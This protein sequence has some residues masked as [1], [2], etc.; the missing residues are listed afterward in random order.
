VAEEARATIMDNI[1]QCENEI[2]KLSEINN[3]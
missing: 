3:V 2:A 1:K